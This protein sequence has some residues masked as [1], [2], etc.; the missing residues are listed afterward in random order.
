MAKLSK[1]DI[2]AWM[3]E[4]DE[5]DGRL[6]MLRNRMAVHLPDKMGTRRSH[7]EV[8]M[9]GLNVSRKKLRYGQ[10]K[11]KLLIK[12]EFSDS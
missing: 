4:M 12:G 1:N 11:L 5:L 2:E 6:E 9:S 7:I 8:A 10:T 3:D